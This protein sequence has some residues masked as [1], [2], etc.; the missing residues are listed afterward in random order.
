ML[1][2]LSG[3]RLPVALNPGFVRH[4]T[5]SAQN[6]VTDSDV[7]LR[8]LEI[9]GDNY[10]GTIKLKKYNDVGIVGGEVSTID[11][12]V[13]PGPG[14]IHN[15]SSDFIKI[16]ST[17][18]LKSISKIT[19]EEGNNS[20]Q[21]SYIYIPQVGEENVGNYVTLTFPPFIA[22]DGDNTNCRYAKSSLPAFSDFVLSRNDFDLGGLEMNFKGYEPAG[23]GV[24]SYPGFAAYSWDQLTKERF[25]S[26]ITDYVSKD[27][28]NDFLNIG[29]FD[30]SNVTVNDVSYHTIYSCIRTE[31]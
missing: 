26:K 18:A 5:I 14:I 2:T 13:Q 22:V 4:N 28:S 9:G 23:T 3:N 29:K 31:N 30:V 16:D 21:E 19:F 6:V 20:D 11:G 12:L 17:E 27:P 24:E 1:G 25:D 15:L 8:V 7:G 10:Q